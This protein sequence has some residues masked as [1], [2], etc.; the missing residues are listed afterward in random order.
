MKCPIQVFGNDKMKVA[1]ANSHMVKYNI[2]SG[3]K[4]LH[5]VFSEIIIERAKEMDPNPSMPILQSLFSQALALYWDESRC[6]ELGMD[7]LNL[8]DLCRDFSPLISFILSEGSW[9]YVFDILN[10]AERKCAKLNFDILRSRIYKKKDFIEKAI[11]Y[12]LQACEFQ[13]MEQLQKAMSDLKVEERKY[14]TYNNLIACLLKS[15]VT[16]NERIAL[17]LAEKFFGAK[18]SVDYP[19]Q[20]TVEQNLRTEHPDYKIWSDRSQEN[21]EIVSQKDSWSGSA[22]SQHDVQN[23]IR[24]LSKTDDQ[25]EFLVIF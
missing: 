5:S 23:V 17:E 21:T 14:K 8:R 22:Y 7:M 4:L 24:S 3:V 11:H 15:K 9:E 19:I 18:C 6:Y 13:S 10:D 25:F 16:Q 2:H 1:I 12:A 20:S